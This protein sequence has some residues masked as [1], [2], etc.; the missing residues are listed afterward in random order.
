MAR[1][2]PFR[3]CIIPFRASPWRADRAAS[4]DMAAFR[5]RA[6]AAAGDSGDLGSRARRPSRRHGRRHR[7]QRRFGLAFGCKERDRKCG[8][9]PAS[10]GRSS[11]GAAAAATHSREGSAATA[12]A[13][14]KPGA[15]AEHAGAGPACGARAGPAAQAVAAVATQRSAA[16]SSPRAKPSAAALRRTGRAAA[17]RSENRRTRGHRGALA[18]RCRRTWTRGGGQRTQCRRH[19]RHGLWRRQLSRSRHALDQPFSALSGSG[20]DEE[21]GRHGR[22]RISLHA[23]RHDPRCLGGEK[24]RLSAPRQSGR[25]HGAGGLSDP[26]GTQAGSVRD[27]HHGLDAGALLDRPFRQA[28]PLRRRRGRSVSLLRRPWRRRRV[29]ARRTAYSDKPCRNS[30]SS[31]HAIFLAETTR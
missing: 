29:A 21:A 13:G 30:G 2:T 22:R 12:R 20:A 8:A 10:T 18:R 16:A 15:R 4:S 7:Q 9:G 17:G 27:L 14:A 23:W 28:V 25:R 1:P 11:A 6:G 31:G 19:A 26:S 3:R 5:R 24:L